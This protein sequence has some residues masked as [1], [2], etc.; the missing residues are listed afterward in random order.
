MIEAKSLN[1]HK[2][3]YRRVHRPYYSHS[4]PR[5]PREA[6]QL[7]LQTSEPLVICLPLI[8]RP[9]G[10]VSG[11]S[12]RLFLLNS[13][14]LDASQRLALPRKAAVEKFEVQLNEP[15]KKQE[16]NEKSPDFYANLG[17]AIRTL[18]EDLP[19]LFVKDLNYDVYRDDIIFKDPN[20]SFQGKRNYKLIIWSLKFHGSLFFKKIYIDVQRIWQPDDQ[21]IKIRFKLHA[22][23]RVWWE[24]EGTFDGIFTYKL[25]KEGKIYEHSV[26][27]IQLRDPPITNPLLY[28]L[29][30]LSRQ[31]MEPQIPVPGGYCKRREEPASVFRASFDT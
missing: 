28:G 6:P 17:D 19:L 26:N 14:R 23:P 8:D 25:D 18:R 7:A 1:A 22:Y 5:I 9:E 10:S 13:D 11:L 15:P 29:N 27:N 21:Q 24:T 3:S 2:L 4:K 30:L 16:T 20:I 12:N 31:H